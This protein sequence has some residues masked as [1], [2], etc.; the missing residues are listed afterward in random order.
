MTFVE[1][2]KQAE[3]I[4]SGVIK[5]HTPPVFE[6][7]RA[8]LNALGDL[9]AFAQKSRPF[10]NDDVTLGFASA[11]GDVVQRLSPYQASAVAKLGEP[12]TFN[13]EEFMDH[14]KGQIEKALKEEPGAGL[15]RLHALRAGINKASY[16]GTDRVAIPLYVDPFQQ[17]TLETEGGVTEVTSGTAGRG[18]DLGVKPVSLSLEDIMS[19]TVRDLQKSV[20]AAQIDTGWQPDLTS[21]AFLRGER[22]HDFG[23]DGAK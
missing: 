9:V 20:E 6:T 4:V 14:F 23:R 21:A 13:A 22:R 16:F 7:C 3:K 10:D 18:G 2:L 11:I 12:K 5:E 15:A 1:L 19:R 8:A 17:A